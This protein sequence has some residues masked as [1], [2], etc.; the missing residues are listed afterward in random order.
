MQ[1]SWQADNQNS[2]KSVSHSSL[3]PL[4][5]LGS[6]DIGCEASASLDLNLTELLS[7]GFADFP[8]PGDGFNGAGMAGCRR[9]EAGGTAAAAGEGFTA[10]DF[11]TAG[12]AGA[13]AVLFIVKNRIVCCRCSAWADNSSAIDA[14]SSDAEAFC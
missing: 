13:E 4:A 1:K 8:V 5:S 7:A 14:A 11:F 9:F 12:A 6:T 3:L 10:E 2:I